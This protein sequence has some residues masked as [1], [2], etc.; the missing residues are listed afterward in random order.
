VV[1]VQIDPIPKYHTMKMFRE[2]RGKASIALPLEV[3]DQLHSLATAFL[4][5]NL[6]ASLD[7]ILTGPQSQHFK[8]LQKKQHN[9]QNRYMTEDI[10][11][12]T[13]YNIYSIFLMR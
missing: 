5:R 13:I 8:Y 9:V 3:S 12:T 2:C 11:L 1:K 7:K 6:S 10:F 4:G